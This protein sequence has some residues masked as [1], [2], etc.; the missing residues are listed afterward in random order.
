MIAI[1]HHGCL[2]VS[3]ECDSGS[4]SGV[5]R[6]LP[7][8][9]ESK[10][11]KA[12][13][14]HSQKFLAIAFQGGE[15]NF[16]LIHLC[17]SN[18][19]SISSQLAG[20]PT[21]SLGNFKAIVQ[22]NM[23]SSPETR[24]PGIM[25][26]ASFEALQWGHQAFIRRPFHLVLSSLLKSVC[27]SLSFLSLTDVFPQHR[28]SLPRPSETTP[29]MAAVH[30]HESAIPSLEGGDEKPM[31]I[32]LE[33]NDDL[34]AL[35]ARGHVAT[36]QYVRRAYCVHSLLLSHPFQ[37]DTPSVAFRFFLS[38]RADRSSHSTQRPKPS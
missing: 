6:C 15:C 24:P 19:P 17:E 3:W 22:N 13:C 7:C 31:A 30:K 20:H 10:R 33:D 38:C 8:L 9:P 35:A 2:K 5:R 18:L 37:A 25:K 1:A 29:T 32:P 4:S 12:C 23:G 27:S 21:L 34:Q 14:T 36:D 28:L 11:H 16:R 26:Y